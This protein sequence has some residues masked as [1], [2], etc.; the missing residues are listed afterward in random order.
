MLLLYDFFDIPVISYLSRKS[1]TQQKRVLAYYIVLSY[2]KKELFSSYFC[3]FV[4]L[5]LQSRTILAFVK[6]EKIYANGTHTYLFSLSLKLGF[7][8]HRN[9][10]HFQCRHIQNL[11]ID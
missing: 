5:R 1:E 7:D 4:K 9:D 3:V 11:H 10:I 6:K 8:V 2:T